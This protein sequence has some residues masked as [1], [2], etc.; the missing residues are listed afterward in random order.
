LT[1]LTKDGNLK[2]KEVN[3][4]ESRKEKRRKEAG[5]KDNG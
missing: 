1:N 2:G 3:H 4:G 5:K